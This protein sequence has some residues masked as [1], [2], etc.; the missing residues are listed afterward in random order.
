M[1]QERAINFFQEIGEHYKAEIIGDLS[2]DEEISIYKQGEWLDLCR[3]PHLPSTGRI[4]KAFKLTKI[5]GAYWR[6]ISGVSSFS[7]FYGT[8]WQR[9][10]AER[11]S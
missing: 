11:I 6:G 8:C 3:G 5:A 2:I 1:G 7:E 10:R 9:K 4:G